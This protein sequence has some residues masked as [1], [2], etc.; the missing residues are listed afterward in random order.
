MMD[1][2]EW[3]GEAL[4]QTAVSAPTEP[5]IPTAGYLLRDE[6]T[7]IA[8]REAALKDAPPLAAIGARAFQHAHAGGL[9]LWDL[10]ADVTE[11]F[12]LGRLRDELSNPVIRVLVALWEG[13]AIGFAQLRPATP[14]FGPPRDRSLELYGI[15]VAPDW[16]G[17]G[18]G[19]ALV[20]G[21]FA[22]GR[23]VRSERIWVSIWKGNGRARS[24]LEGWGF[25]HAG[26]RALSVG[27][28]VADVSVLVRPLDLEA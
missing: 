13:D 18:V 9:N 28:R 17:Q 24:F 25:R 2:K 20:R 12:D 10:A 23:E 22:L 15:Y 11:R 7:G 8:V 21:A 1:V 4:R 27:R 19:S 3:L 26:E 14:S 5:E 6:R 16:M